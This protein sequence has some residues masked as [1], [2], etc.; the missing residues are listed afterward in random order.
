MTFP[1]DETA[2][3]KRLTVTGFYLPSRSNSFHR[4]THGLQ[5]SAGRSQGCFCPSARGANAPDIAALVLTPR[6]VDPFSVP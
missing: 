5:P 6:V 4:L 2:N 3:P 1:S